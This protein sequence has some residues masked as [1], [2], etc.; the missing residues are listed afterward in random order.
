[1]THSLIHDY[2]MQR[3][4]ALLCFFVKKDKWDYKKVNYIAKSIIIFFTRFPPYGTV[5]FVVIIPY[6]PF[7]AY[8]SLGIHSP[9]SP[10]R[11][12]WISRPTPACWATF[13][14]DSPWTPMPMWQ[15]QPKKKPPPPWEMCSVCE[16]PICWCCCQNWPSLCGKAAT[17][18]SRRRLL[19]FLCVHSES[20]FLFWS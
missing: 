18:F 14:Q 5:I 7:S 3:S 16:I 15:L 13:P 19:R 6:S 10:C 1:M 12:A 17:V 20:F 8:T 2:F 4:H 11:T 9:P